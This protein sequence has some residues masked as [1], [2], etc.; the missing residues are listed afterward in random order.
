MEIEKLLMNNNIINQIENDQ[1]LSL[2]N[3]LIEIKEKKNQEMID[4]LQNLLKNKF[5]S[6]LASLEKH[7]KKH[8]LIINNTLR[9][10][11]TITDISKKM[12]NEINK[13]KQKEK[14]M[15]FSKFSKSS[16]KLHLS[17]N[18][19][20]TSK[21]SENISKTPIRAITNRS[22]FKNSNNNLLKRLKSDSK[23]KSP[24]VIQRRKVT[25]DDK[26]LKSPISLRSNKIKNNINDN[27][28]SPS[29]INLYRKNIS[30]TINNKNKRKN[31]NIRINTIS[32]NISRPSVISNET[33][34]TYITSESSKSSFI[35]PKKNNLKSSRFKND[36]ISIEKTPNRKASSK[37]NIGLIGKMKKNLDKNTDR[38]TSPKK[39]NLIKQE[40]KKEKSFN[41]TDYKKNQKKNFFQNNNLT[42][43]NL[44]SR[45]NMQSSDI[46]SEKIITLET[47]LKKEANLIKDDPLLISS[48]KDLGLTTNTF[49][50]NNISKDEININFDKNIDLSFQFK[51][52]DSES[53]EFILRNEFSLFNPENNFI[54]EYLNNILVFLSNKDII[55]LKNCSKNFHKSIIDYLIKKF[56]SERSIFIEKQNELNL[57]IE[58]VPQ[59]PSINDLKLTKGTWKAINLLNEDILNRL[60]QDKKPPNK[61]IL[62]IYKIFFYLIK[63]K[64][65]IRSFEDFDNNVFWEKCK[66]YFRESNEKT[67]DLL[68]NI[69]EQKKIIIDGE[70]IYK[71]YNI[72]HNNIK[73][74]NPTYFSKICGTT[75]LF[76]FFIKDILDFLGFSEDIKIKKYSY[77]S[78]SEIINLLDS[79]INTLNKYQIN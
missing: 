57:Q 22:N 50:V 72:A 27:F 46:S 24:F 33:N 38:K 78:Y 58:E 75:G 36:R 62:I 28:N 10:T 77:W 5:E 56:D 35:I 51:A 59:K 53:K 4:M 52:N 70:N 41:E 32:E 1:K 49:L 12:L 18:R 40:N 42:T 6:K 9:T 48:I 54:D 39:K 69:F 76:V 21:N 16:K 26:N 73:K 55:K 29:K 23:N 20:L 71:I 45:K 44:S 34:N 17:Q 79:K 64:E 67:G 13:R 60:F 11:N 66:N 3:P 43:F 19:I 68:N 2:I 47:D 14:R 8:L 37:K 15:N 65:I 74:I 25:F 61:E 31:N 63:E 30:S 7:S